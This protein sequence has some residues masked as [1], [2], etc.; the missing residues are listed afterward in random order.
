MPGGRPSRYDWDDKYDICYK[1]YVE[2]KKSPREVVK[3]FVEQFS[4]SEA[5]LPR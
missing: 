3:H 1:L 5:D 4:C 2:Q